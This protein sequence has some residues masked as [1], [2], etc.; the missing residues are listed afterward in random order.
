MKSTEQTPKNQGPL[1]PLGFNI[2]YL[3]VVG[4]F[5]QAD[6]A[7]SPGESG[8]PGHGVSNCGWGLATGHPLPN[9][10]SNSCR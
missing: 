7:L 8:N 1:L 2:K 3:M 4:W 9:R 10:G 6:H 5:V